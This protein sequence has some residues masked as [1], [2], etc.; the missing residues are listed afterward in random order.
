MESSKEQYLSDIEVFVTLKTTVQK[1]GVSKNFDFI[2]C[3]GNK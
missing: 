3:G 1:F 2:F